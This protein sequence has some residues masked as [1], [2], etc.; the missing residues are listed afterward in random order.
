MIDIISVAGLISLGFYLLFVFIFVANIWYLSASSKNALSRVFFLLC[1]CLSVWS[2]TF[3]L[4]NSALSQ[5]YAIIWRR[6]S[7]LGWGFAY[8]VILHFVLIL[9]G[10]SSKINKYSLLLLYIPA[11]I[12]FFLFG[13]YNP[14]TLKYINL[15][16]TPYGWAQLPVGGPCDTFF[17]IYYVGYIAISFVLL[18]IWWVRQKDRHE[19]VNAGLFFFSFLFAFVSGSLTDVV[20]NRLFEHPIPS[21]APFSF[22][23]PLIA[24]G[25]IIRRKGFRL[26]EPHEIEIHDDSIFSDSTRKK[27]HFYLFINY[28][29]GSLISIAHS[30][31]YEIS[32]NNSI[33][34]SAGLVLLGGV[35]FYIP[36]MNLKI[37][38]KDILTVFFVAI[39][40]PVIHFR[41]L[42]ENGSRTVWALPLVFMTISVV[43]NRRFFLVVIATVS[44]LVAAISW[45][46]AP[47]LDPFF[48]PFIHFSRILFLIIGLIFSF[49]IKKLYFA[50]TL[51]LQE[52]NQQ[53]SLSEQILKET[54]E[55]VCVISPEGR[56]LSVNASFCSMTGYNAVELL[57]ENFMMIN[58]EQQGESFFAN[59]KEKTDKY[60]R[61][62]GEVWNRR[63]DGEK[64]P[65]WV[66]L[67][68]VKDEHKTISHY[69]VV[70]SDISKIKTAEERIRKLAYFDSLTGLPNR[71]YFNQILE[72]T[73][74]RANKFYKMTVLM[75]VD[76][77]RFKNVN[78]SLGHSSG[79]EVLIIVAERLKKVVKSSDTVA[80]LGGDEF[81]IV[82]EDLDSPHQ[83][84]II[85]KRVLEALSQPIT[86]D[87]REFIVGASI[88]IA[89]A[90]TDDVTAEGLLMKADA[91]LYYSKNNGRGNFSFYSSEVQLRQK[92]YLDIEEKMK[93]GLK[94]GGFKLFLQPQICVTKTNNYL[95]GAEALLRLITPDNQMVPPNEFIQIAEDVGM[96]VD[97]GNFVIEESARLASELN[98][99]GISLPISINIS[100]RQLENFQIVSVIK[101]AILLNRIKAKDLKIEVTESLFYKD[102]PKIIAILSEIKSLGIE[103]G[104]DDFGTGFSS[105]SSLV[106]LP[107]DFL[108]ID[109][110]FIDRLGSKDEKGLVAT[111]MTIA[112]NMNL[113]IVVEGL[114]KEEQL[115][116][117]KKYYPTTIQGYYFSRPLPYADFVNFYKNFQKL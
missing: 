72:K 68:T 98:K 36:F 93:C 56:F 100:V 41:F 34:F 75:F 81:T 12:T 27:F 18:I 88:G 101:D 51:Q 30:F 97:I 20:A 66:S 62:Q 9:T 106:K 64:I 60:G 83:A 107:I 109:K 96:I 3:A 32:L 95:C 84:I 80:R 24:L 42:F 33:V 53:L 76:L 43:F 73:L 45:A 50:R 78:D 4:S 29:I 6:F 112:K 110:S 8:S 1:L 114:E 57:D 25:I 116:F 49:Y 111:I 40:I 46:I 86:L 28:I 54:S 26:V 105:L 47:T 22:T 82:L 39:S 104:I 58:S 117:L 16:Q 37:L 65:N 15:V 48:T 2:L 79:D 31:Y 103:I 11:V 113:D 61:W 59:V 89:I 35:V 69:I 44:F 7:A 115:L 102:V 77:D 74:V 91:T 70:V 92:K 38:Y 63:K 67:N 71:F 5:D 10:Y 21:I 90:P 99:Q 85:A 108:K 23:V 52:A 19:R 13:L 14:T 87:N 17:Y 55:G 94:N